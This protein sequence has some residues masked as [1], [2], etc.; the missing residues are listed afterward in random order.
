MPYKGQSHNG[1]GL[2]YKDYANKIPR[3]YIHKNIRYRLYEVMYDY[4]NYKCDVELFSGDTEEFLSKMQSEDFQ[5]NPVIYA[6]AEQ[7]FLRSKG[8]D[9]NREYV[10]K[11]LNAS[12]WGVRD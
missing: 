1:S 6:I 2:C 10:D 7:R 12:R 5:F 11:F 4:V 3:K 8:I 9:S